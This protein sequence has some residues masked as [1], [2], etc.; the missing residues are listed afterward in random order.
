[1]FVAVRYSAAA[2]ENIRLA[3]FGLELHPDK[4]RRIVSGFPS[5]LRFRF[6]SAYRPNSV[7]NGRGSLSGKFPGTFD[8]LGFTH[9]SGK[10]SL[11]RAFYAK[12]EQACKYFVG[13]DPTTDP[14]SVLWSPWR[15]GQY[16]ALK[17]NK[18]GM[19]QVHEAVNCRSL[20]HVAQ[21]FLHK[22]W[23]GEDRAW[24]CKKREVLLHL[25]R[26]KKLDYQE[27]IYNI[28]LCLLARG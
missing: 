7:S 10:N 22:L 24:T 23:S 15:S 4:T 18:A 11:G 21:Y 2:D 26:E 8:F 17:R 12:P 6:S 9:I 5:P 28:T 3:K 1:V 27:R 25:S 14:S 19:V 16:N 13:L 20:D